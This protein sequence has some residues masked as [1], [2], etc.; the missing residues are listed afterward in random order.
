[1]SIFKDLQSYAGKWQVKSVE[2]FTEEDKS[3][4]SRAHVVSSQYG[5][6]V[7]FFMKRGNMH[8]IPLDQ[9]CNAGVGD[10]VDLNSAKLV[11]LEKDGEADIT[12]VRL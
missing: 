8:F 2:N 3:L 6:S 10:E 11:T 7:C 9:N 12:R 1:M 5:L 4:V